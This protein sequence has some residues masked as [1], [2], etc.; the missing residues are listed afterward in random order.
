MSAWKTTNYL[1]FS[2]RLKANGALS[3]IIE[4]CGKEGGQERKKKTNSPSNKG[5]NGH[6]GCARDGKRRGRK[7]NEQLNYSIL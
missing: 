3:S 6:T 5:L 4:F 1:I 7:T 2:V